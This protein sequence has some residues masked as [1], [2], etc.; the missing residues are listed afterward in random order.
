VDSLQ[1]NSGEKRIAINQDPDRMIVF[2][3]SDVMFAEKFYRLVG[4]FQSK[5]KEYR[6]QFEELEKVTDT[7]EHGFPLNMSARFDM[8][9][10]VCEYINGQIDN[11]FGKGA[12][13]KAFKGAMELDLYSQFF[14]GMTPFVQQARK[15]K[16]AKYT[17]QASAKR[18]KRK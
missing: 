2:N 6:A 1:I 16:L 3:P 18:N 5:S 4:D 7:D 17:T 11:L 9:K 15:D 14:E 10:E 8:L 12:A 13:E